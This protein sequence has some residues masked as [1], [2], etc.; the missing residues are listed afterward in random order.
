[1]AT[2]AAARMLVEDVE[3]DQPQA[4]EL[5][6]LASFAVR[7]D[8]PLLRRL[9]LELLPGNSPALEADVWHGGLVT[10][11]GPE[12]FVFAPGVGAVLRERLASDASRY[13]RAWSITREV[14]APWLSP[15]L[16]LEEELNYHQLSQ[17]PGAYDEARELLRK[18]VAW[19]VREKSPGMAYWAAGAA[20]RLPSALMDMEE[21]RMLAAA[22]PAR[23]PGSLRLPSPPSGS[24]PEWM[25]WVAPEGLERIRL[26][27]KMSPLSLTLDPRNESHEDF[28]EL[29]RTNPLVVEVAEADADDEFDEPRR[30]FISYGL[31]ERGVQRWNHRIRDALRRTPH[32]VFPED[33]V[34]Q[35]GTSWRE[36][37]EK[38]L[39][40]CDAAILL[41]FA[42][43]RYSGFQEEFLLERQRKDPEGFTLIVV[44]IRPENDSELLPPV[45]LPG[46]FVPL[47]MFEAS[48]GQEQQVIRRILEALK[49]SRGAPRFGRRFDFS[50]PGTAR[51]AHSG[52]ALRLRTLVGDEYII[53]P[54]RLDPRHVPPPEPGP[55]AHPQAFKTLLEEFDRSPVIA[56]TGPAGV[57]K[58][59]LIR[60]ALSQA[61]YVFRY[62]SYSLVARGSG[63]PPSAQSIAWNLVRAIAPEQARSRED[64]LRLYRY[65]TSER[66][67]A[68]VL[69]DVDSL[70]WSNDAQAVAEINALHPARGSGSVLLLTSRK[71]IER[72]DARWIELGGMES[73]LAVGM[74]MRLVPQASEH[75]AAIVEACRYLAIPMYEVGKAIAQLPSDISIE[76]Y[77][78][79]LRQARMLAVFPESFNLGAAETVLVGEEPSSESELPMAQEMLQAGLL[80]SAGLG[81]YVLW[82]PIRAVAEAEPGEPESYE[83][84]WRHAGH[85]LRLLESLHGRYMQGGPARAEAIAAFDADSANIVVTIEWLLVRLP[86]L[87]EEDEFQRMLSSL[88]AAAPRL[89]RLRR[90]PRERERWFNYASQL[91]DDPLVLLES[92]IAEAE[93]GQQTQALD[94]CDR[95]RDLVAFPPEDAASKDIVVKLARFQLEAG[96]LEACRS[97]L[98]ELPPLGLPS[99]DHGAEW[100]YVTALLYSE[101]GRGT[102]ADW[103]MRIARALAVSEGDIRLEG[104]VQRGLADLAM[105][106]NELGRAAALHEEALE[107]ARAWRDDRG[108]ALASWGLGLVRV[109]QGLRERA[110]E[111]LQ[112]LVDHYR[113]IEHAQAE[114]VARQREVLLLPPRRTG[115]SPSRDQKP[116]VVEDILRVST[117]RIALYVRDRLK[118]DEEIAHDAAV[119]AVVSYLNNPDRYDP[120]KYDLDEYLS[121][122]ALHQARDRSRA[123]FAKSRR[124]QQFASELE[125]SLRDPRE[126]MEQSVEANN[127]L[128]KLVARGYLKDEKDMAALAMLL[129]GERSTERLAKA[130]GLDALKQEQMRREVKRQRDRLMKILERFGRQ[131]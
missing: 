99:S 46:G 66:R 116:V 115:E 32:Q 15:A 28:I 87:S 103:E 83:A 49:R 61:G 44:N 84:A 5:A 90:P 97:T 125:L 39:A 107:F 72:V 25:P 91:Q 19:V 130:L 73:G 1:M 12:G 34:P 54:A 10:F 42:P 98:K 122:A 22:A 53:E 26:G 23:L 127:A 45:V 4:V 3:R 96:N 94:T 38:E 50:P 17:K 31:A 58:T 21:G 82:P 101:E 59:Q 64:A 92:A 108:A 71:R 111:F 56:I 88:M 6:S 41:F 109:R 121:Q 65:L 67:M 69:E 123:A 16:L 14:H 102:E 11:R 51:I 81:R 40:G 47:F 57:G 131:S 112:G 29:P 105:A 110:G 104:D 118:C 70:G 9:R 120:S 80:R 43:T 33:E 77:V 95:A 114:Q 24:V 75:A 119:D 55:I 68:L 86:G 126:Q 2:L 36:T 78:L 63:M 100:H 52:Q 89:L 62:G 18:A 79:L 27:V 30:I 106:R 129:Q 93:L 113:F 48:A 85:Y 128:K 20:I 35:P 117:P 76:R 13:E 124:E 60:Q 37:L 7:V 8:P 74:L